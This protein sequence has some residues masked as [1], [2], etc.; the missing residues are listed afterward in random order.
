MTE[1][2]HAKFGG[3]NAAVW[4]NC[5][6]SPGL[7]AQ[8]PV[9]PTNQAAIDGTAL[10]DCMDTLLRN[11]DKQPKDFLGAKVK[12]VFIEQSHILQLEIALAA[13]EEICGELDDSYEIKSEQRVVI[14]N[15]AWGTADVLFYTKKHMKIVDFK[16]GNEI[17]EAEMNDQEL[18]YAVGARK[19]LKI[20]P[21]TIELIVIQPAM[22]PAMDRHMV[23]AKILDAF[24]ESIY[25]A[26]KAATAPHPMPIEGEWCKWPSCKLICPLKL[27]PIQTLTLPNHALKLDDV[28][29]LLL[30][31]EQMMPWVDQARERIHHELDHGV[32]VKGWKL[33]AKRAIRQ[34][35]DEDKA[36]AMF[37][38]KKI[39]KEAYTTTKLISP[40]QAE[41]LLDK[42][43]IAELANPVSSG[44]TIAPETDKRPAVMAAAALGRAINKL[45]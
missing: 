43:I 42:K 41:K 36:I 22:D 32:S 10:H 28:G 6:A 11:A 40:A 20:A 9:S 25:A 18:F 2:L 19:T 14:N 23:D 1:L 13:Y 4:M 45:T 38:T 7:I 21:E 5:A 3:S 17:V 34:W 12:G 33:V 27:K 24:E 16:F 8:L 26:L 44:T 30:K 31:I 15:D 37:K 39:T 29:A 35:K